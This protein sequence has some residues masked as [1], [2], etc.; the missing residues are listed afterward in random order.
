MYYE[1]LEIDPKLVLIVQSCRGYYQIASSRYL[2]VICQLAHIK[3]FA[4][5]RNEL[6]QVVNTELNANC[7]SLINNKVDML[8]PY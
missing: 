4:K 2:D 8:A 5:C 1:R 3:M 7:E 6:I